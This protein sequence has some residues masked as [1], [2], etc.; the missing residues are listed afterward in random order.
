MH[1]PPTHMI[2]LKFCE[3]FLREI[4]TSYES[5]LAQKFP[6]EYDYTKS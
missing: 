6:A 2:D 5:F 3:S 1:A 4:L